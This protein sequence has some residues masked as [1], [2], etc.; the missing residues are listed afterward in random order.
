MFEQTI[1]IDRMGIVETALCVDQALL[2]AGNLKIVAQAGVFT[3]VCG[4]KIVEQRVGP[5]LFHGKDRP[6]LMPKGAKRRQNFIFD[7]E[8]GARL[9]SGQKE[10]FLQL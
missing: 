4:F 2:P 1:N 6:F 5:C 7:A 3:A 9:I 8:N 10:L